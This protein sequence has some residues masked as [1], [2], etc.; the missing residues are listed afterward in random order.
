MTNV[1]DRGAPSYRSNESG[2]AIVM[3][4]LALSIF[5][6]AATAFAV[7]FT[8]LWFHRQSA[9]AAAD[10]A[11]GAGVQEMLSKV[12]DPSFEPSFPESRILPVGPD[13]GFDC[14]SMNDVDPN[15]IMAPCWYAREN[16]HNSSS[17]TPGSTVHVSWPAYACPGSGP[18]DT[19][20][21][22]PGVTPAATSPV[23]PFL[24]IDIVERVEVF[25]FGLLNGTRTQP[26][27]VAAV[28][29][30]VAQDS[31]VPISLLHPHR[32][33][34]LDVGGGAIIVIA[35]GAG[36]SFAVNSD[37][38]LA[39]SVPNNSNVN[40]VYAGR[41]YCGGIFSVVGALSG[42]LTTSGWPLGGTSPSCTGTFRTPV[43]LPSSV[44]PDPLAQVSA[45]SSVPPDGGFRHVNYGEDGCPDQA[46]GC[47]E[48]FPGRHSGITV[49]AGGSVNKETAIFA[50]GL[51]YIEGGDFNL[52][53]NSCVRP[54]LPA[55][56]AGCS[57]CVSNLPAMPGNVNFQVN[58]D[59]SGGT[60][61]YF[62]DGHTLTVTGGACNFQTPAIQPFPTALE[63]CA[64]SSV[65]PPFVPSTISDSVLMAPCS[66]TYGDPSTTPDADLGVQRGLLLFQNRARRGEVNFS[67]QGTLLM[68]GAMYAHRCTTG[69]GIDVGGASCVSPSSTSCGGIAGN[70]SS[71]CS[72]INFNGGSGSTTFVLGAVVTDYLTIGGNGVLAMTLNPGAVY[73][74]YKAS[75]FR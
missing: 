74:A 61:F 46:S 70:T 24:R 7:D 13:S 34:A 73:K 48:Y 31:I 22:A 37:S 4:L 16:G 14:P 43:V 63:K 55:G 18:A 62:A 9:Q 23:H 58:G 60:T 57:Y 69:N 26:V 27:R 32:D 29:G 71:F 75:L 41:D 25:F 40:L 65:I 68:A 44:A 50:P 19:G 49:A 15:L 35:G 38:S 51:Y 54:T 36:R 12:N 72:N 42:A 1:A 59:G 67:G 64:N 20:C 21:P 5:L 10:A 45:P 3:V 6:L 30:L 28:C 2:Q 53:N 17:A 39:A 56:S 47:T 11:C 8:N 52:K 33:K 66:G